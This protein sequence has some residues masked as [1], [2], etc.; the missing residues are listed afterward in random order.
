MR[1]PDFEGLSY[2]E[3]LPVLNAKLKGKMKWVW[4]GDISA[5]YDEAAEKA[6]LTI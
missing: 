1:G 6:G 5:E 3:C 4:A 2:D